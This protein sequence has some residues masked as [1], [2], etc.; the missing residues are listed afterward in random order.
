MV[1]PGLPDCQGMFLQ[2]AAEKIQAMYR[3]RMVREK[4]AP[5]LQLVASGLAWHPKQGG[6]IHT[7]LEK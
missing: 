1:M 6:F 2:A 7:I 3:G 4:Q 5:L